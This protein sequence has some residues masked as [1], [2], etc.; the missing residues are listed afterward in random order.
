MGGVIGGLTTRE[1][2]SLETNRHCAHSTLQVEQAA[3]VYLLPTSSKFQEN[4]LLTLLL[5]VLELLY[6]K[7]LVRPG[8]FRVDTL[9][10]GDCG[11]DGRRL[12]RRNPSLLCS[13]FE[14]EFEF[15]DGS[16]IVN[17]P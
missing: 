16:R 7:F 8:P 12:L 15:S 13:E 4:L 2:T 10:R 5:L 1:L 6:L 14:F 17:I 9:T 11:D 3:N